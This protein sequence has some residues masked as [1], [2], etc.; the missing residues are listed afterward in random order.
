MNLLKQ[1]TFYDRLKNSTV[2]L[3][4]LIEE[5]YLFN[6]NEEQN[7]YFYLMFY[8][9]ANWLPDTFNKHLNDKLEYFSRNRR[10]SFNNFELI[11]VSSDK[12][13]EAYKEFMLK[14]KFIRYSLEFRPDNND[15]K[16]SYKQSKINKV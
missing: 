15:L 12:T 7:H 10:Q 5:N 16:V 8:F 4:D 14:N 13:I 1:C 6:L 11:F 9:T 3:D 2:E